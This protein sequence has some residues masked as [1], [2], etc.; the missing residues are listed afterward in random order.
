MV[1]AGIRWQPVPG[2]E[3]DLARYR[4]E[5]RNRPRK[6]DDDPDGALEAVGRVAVEGTELSAR[7]HGQDCNLRLAAARNDARNRTDG[8][9]YE[10]KRPVGVPTASAGLTTNC[11]LATPAPLPD[12][13]SWR[14]RWQG[15]RWADPANTRRVHAHT[16]H[17]LTA[18]WDLT[19]HQSLTLDAVNLTDRDHIRSVTSTS[20]IYQGPTRRLFL[21]WRARL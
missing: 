20:N 13:L 3:V 14:T 6:V 18:G 19:P 15:H 2:A 9:K 8:A 4:L 5:E 21:G 10:D 17:G 12:R 11:R 7:W 16:V 1:E